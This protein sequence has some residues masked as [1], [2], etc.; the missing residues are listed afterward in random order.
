MSERVE[1]EKAIQ[2]AM[3][4]L[5]KLFEESK[6]RQDRNNE[7][8]IQQF[9]NRRKS[10]VELEDFYVALAKKDSLLLFSEALPMVLG[11]KQAEWRALAPKL[12]RSYAHLEELARSSL[13]VSLQVVNPDQKESKWRVPSKDFVEWVCS[14]IDWVKPELLNAFGIKRKQDAVAPIKNE[15]NAERH[16]RNREKVLSAALAVL[17]VAPEKCKVNGKITGAAIA[18]QIDLF[19][20][21]VYG[22]YEEPPLGHRK[23][24]EVINNAL[25]L[26]EG[27]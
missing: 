23:T 6:Q 11:A 25:R 5:N 1:P 16:A 12:S 22:A 18:K 2:D 13:G 19:S 26:I 14:K 8:L 3:E 24:L 20:D 21:Y 9:L 7:L 4:G 10:N 27:Q 17:A 15:I